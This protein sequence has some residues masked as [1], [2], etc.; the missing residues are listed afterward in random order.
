[1]PSSTATESPEPIT[2][3]TSSAPSTELEAETA[4]VLSF[5]PESGYLTIAFHSDLN[6]EYSSSNAVF[7]EFIRSIQVISP[8]SATMEISLT[9]QTGYYW[10]SSSSEHVLGIYGL[11]AQQPYEN[12]QTIRIIFK[13]MFNQAEEQLISDGSW[14][15]VEVVVPPNE[16][17]GTEPSNPP[18]TPPTDYPGIPGTYPPIPGMPPYEIP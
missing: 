15:E 12:G 6:S 8:H 13:E 11:R 10:E 1:M 17:P 9:N 5:M 2:S 16:N 7:T 14:I 18:G 3:P 4:R